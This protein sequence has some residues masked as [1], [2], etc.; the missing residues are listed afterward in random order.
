MRSRANLEAALVVELGFDL[1]RARGSQRALALIRRR[2]RMRWLPTPGAA[3]DPRLA[4]ALAPIAQAEA[5]AL[6]VVVCGGAGQ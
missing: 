3:S 2:D 6:R 5:R 1:G 4:A